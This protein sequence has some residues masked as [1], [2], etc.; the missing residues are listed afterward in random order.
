MW[1]KKRQQQEDNEDDDYTHYA[2]G[3]A[4]MKTV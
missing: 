1:K 2:G 3:H 4:T